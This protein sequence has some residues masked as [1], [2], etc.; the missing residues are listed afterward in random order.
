MG[1][2][3]LRSSGGSGGGGLQELRRT[4]G[5]GSHRGGICLPLCASRGKT[6][7]HAAVRDAA[8]RGGA[9]RKTPPQGTTTREGSQRSRA[10]GTRRFRC[11]L[12][13]GYEAQPR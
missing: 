2:A 6:V 4:G 9:A 1:R 7:Q 8:N 5:L 10:V 3:K 11:I 12:L 13:R